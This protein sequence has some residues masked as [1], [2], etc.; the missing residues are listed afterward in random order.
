MRI[1]I[2]AAK[3]K[4]RKALLWAGFAVLAAWAAGFLVAPYVAKPLLIRALEGKF[5]R[6]VAIREIHI[7]PVYLSARVNGIAMGERDGGDPFLTVD[8]LYL[9]LQA[10]SLWEWAPVLDEIAIKAPYLRIVRKEDSTYNF[11]DIV[12]ELMKPSDAPALYSL[13]NV[14]LQGGRI[15][16]DDRPKHARHTVS[17]L[18][19]AIPFLSNLHYATDIY[20]KPVLA[21]RVNGA[22]LRLDGQSKP[23]SSSRES[24]VQLNLSEVDIPDYLKYLPVALKFE[25]PSARLDA[26]LTISFM[27]LPNR[28]PAVALSGTASLKAV[29][30]TQGDN[31]LLLSLSGLSV[32]IASADISRKKIVL[33][34]VILNHPELHLRRG[35][36]GGFN[37]AAVMPDSRQDQAAL[38]AEKTPLSLEV[39]DIK[40]SGGVV[41]FADDTLPQPFQGRVQDIDLAIKNFSTE[42]GKPASVDATFASDAG[43]T[44]KSSGQ[45]T[46]TPFSA[47]GTAQIGR[48]DLKRYAPYYA[49]LVRFDVVAGTLD[50]SARYRLGGGGDSGPLLQ[51]DEL[52][53][54][55]D[56]LRLRQHGE[57]AE[58]L[59]IGT[60]ALGGGELDLGR[61]SLTVAD[62]TTE[63]GS[64][65]ATRGADGRINLANLTAPSGSS[66]PALATDSTAPWQ[67]V[68]KKLAV[69]GYAAQFQ[70][71]AVG[72]VTTLA[73]DAIK[74]RAENLS[75]QKD[76]KARVDLQARLGKSGHLRA[77]GDA[78]LSP[79]AATLKIDFKGLALVPLQPYFVEKINVTVTD[80]DVSA[81][82]GLTLSATPGGPI[83]VGFVGD[84]R[85][86][87]FASVDKV[88]A[89]D[90]LKWKTLRFSRV[91]A[92]TQPALRVSI[93]KIELADYYSRL[94]VNPDGTFNLQNVLVKEEKAAQAPE[95]SA[96]T[97]GKAKADSSASNSAPAPA[98]DKPWITIAR[99]TLRN[100]EV[101]F[102]DHF[103]QP[104]YSADLTGLG[105]TVT[106]LSSDPNA[107]ADLALNG[108]VNNQGQLDINGKINP[109]AGNL[110]LDVL[111]KL[112]D[113]ELSPLTPY[114]A[115]YAGYGIEKGKLSFDV[116][117]HVE[118][119]KLTAENHLLL[120]RLTFGER[121]ES[122]TATKLP[123]LFAVALLKDRNDNIDINLPIAGSLD[124][125]QFSMAGIIAKA[126]I[127][128]IVKAVTAPFTLIANLFAG[129][130]ELSH[131][132]FEYGSAA[133]PPD[134]EA[135]LKSLAKA[136]YDRPG[137][138][139]DIAGRA[140]PV[141]DAEGLKRRALE[142]KVK[143][144]KLKELVNEGESVASVEE[145]TIK[146]EEYPKYLAAAYGQ[147]K[148]P[149]K[150][151]Y[152]IGLAKKLPVAE[153]EALMLAHIQVSDEDLHELANR[154]ALSTKDYLVKAGPVESARIYI[155]AP[156]PPEPGQEKL[157]QSRVDFNLGAR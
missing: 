80:G 3:P 25:V 4:L 36:G 57:K 38:P 142:H 112:T 86:E 32:D 19:L 68:L 91:N 153:M 101:N 64:L 41:Q 120:N 59:K 6:P 47:T 109:L 56:G 122:P 139:L 53:G 28:P 152:F 140:D 83:K 116:K 132:E 33:Q 157:K 7:N 98:T 78:V 119:R 34:S 15:E 43:E 85:V 73:A 31:T 137:I 1:P 63:S 76:G 77:S 93:A 9:N 138:K 54:K 125:P 21:A 13:N 5:H 134:T 133:L 55:L 144:Q 27:Q 126:I 148:I 17:D 105:G 74:I 90:F 118:N 107:L 10:K 106:D 72:K 50:A 24:S 20:V 35:K 69:D 75:T 150:P 22:S 44:A 130:Q 58:F 115:K 62:L 61:R 104:N 23:F 82:G 14:Q 12:E 52:T 40:L 16:F 147:E 29:S 81:K 154:R 155:V 96:A 45:L 127:N 156:R 39:R 79:L 89:E 88:T 99:M 128:L 114:A 60:L 121:V 151:R 123:V 95:N 8:E 87:R 37:L 131:L 108:R 129:G 145:V 97:A 49:G 146:P 103:I 102:H 124:D 94:V 42:P 84:A 100:G 18:E 11:G 70:S 110:F 66:Q 71:T 143:A 113:F 48:L 65:M 149:D 117:Y 67:F 2:L 135:K 111:A 26:K 92:A 141:K 46:L 51:L 30:L 136:L